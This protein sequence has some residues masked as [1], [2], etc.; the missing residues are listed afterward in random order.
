MRKYNNIPKWIISAALVVTT[1]SCDKDFLEKN[2]LDSLSSETFWQNEDH[3][4][5]GLAGV[6]ATLTDN[7]LGYERVYFECLSDNA[8]NALP[9]FEQANLYE[10]TIGALSAASGGALNNMFSQPYKAITASNYFLANAD[11]ALVDPLLTE[12]ELDV[13]KAEVRFVRAL[14]YFDVV[15]LWGE[16][17]L[18]TEFPENL[19]EM[20]VP[21]SSSADIYQLIEDDLNFAIATLPDAAYSGHAVKGSAQGLLGKVLLTQEK[22]AEA[23]DVLKILIDGGKFQIADSY[24]DIF[25]KAGQANPSVKR[26]ILFSTK[27][28]AN[29]VHRIDPVPAGLYL[30]LGQQYYLQP[31]ADLADAYQ[32]SNGD[33]PSSTTL[34]SE[35]Y[36]NRDPRLD[37]TIK[38]P[39]ESWPNHVPIFSSTTGFVMEK[40]VDL[41]TMPLTSEDAFESD[42]DFVHLR[43]A[44]ILLMY[45]EAKNEATGPD[46]NVYDALDEVRGRTGVDMPAVDR[47]VN[48]DQ[49]VLREFIR[50]ERRVELA[51]EGH[52]YFDIK[53]WRIA[54][55][56]LDGKPTTNG[57]TMVF[58]ENNYKLPFPQSELDSNPELVQNEGY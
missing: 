12:A 48:A 1:F 42:N 19:E 25:L 11:K 30:E 57:N 4:I 47:T 44:D 33:D 14:A 7:Y 36:E 34:P 52:R 43:Y 22:W 29:D 21:K 24:N 53:R 18:Y 17:P 41:S 13:Y 46:G 35:N 39:N 10:M 2:P 45:A 6:Y 37:M 40:Y 28:S 16:A 49:S 3:V 54:Q 15:Q 31:F 5:T 58:K 26:E 23:A 38:L 55:A 50:N 51:L 27:Y 8:A 56:N 9:N 32:M 20:S